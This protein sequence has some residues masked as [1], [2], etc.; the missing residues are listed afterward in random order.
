MTNDEPDDE[1]REDVIEDLEAPATD[2]DA[3]AGGVDTCG[4]PSMLCEGTCQLTA[5]VCPP[6]YKTHLIINYDR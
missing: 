5:V 3:V 4:N 2:Q 6:A 1:A